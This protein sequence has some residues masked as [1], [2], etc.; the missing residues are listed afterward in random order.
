L[1]LASALTKV[2]LH[3]IE[4]PAYA[5]M[6]GA[7]LLANGS[8]LTDYRIQRLMDAPPLPRTQPSRIRVLGTS[9]SIVLAFVVAQGISC[10]L[11]LT[12]VGC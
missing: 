6:G 4:T 7:Q 9:L 8:A 10:I 2:W 5:M 11:L 1:A 3:R 12:V